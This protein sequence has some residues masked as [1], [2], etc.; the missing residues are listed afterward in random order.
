MTAPGLAFRQ[1]FAA[2]ALADDRPGPSTADQLRAILLEHQRDD[3]RSA[4][5]TDSVQ[6]LREIQNDDGGWAMAR[7]AGQVGDPSDAES[8]GQ[9]LTVLGLCGVA[10]ADAMVRSAL[11]FL[12]RE[13]DLDSGWGNLT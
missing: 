8:T 4:V 11:G 2:P 9:V 6:A 1:D 7:E 13:Q 3:G 5:V 12:E 10:A